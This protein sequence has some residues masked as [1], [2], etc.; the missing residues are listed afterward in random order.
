VQKNIRK[1]LLA[2]NDRHTCYFSAQSISQIPESSTK[3]A[4]RTDALWAGAWACAVAL[5][6]IDWTLGRL[7][8]LMSKSTLFSRANCVSF[9]RTRQNQHTI[10]TLCPRLADSRPHRLWSA[11][12]FL[13]IIA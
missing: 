6:P 8:L 7:D 2:S 13:F 11:A 4:I 3:A 9:V 1:A 12:Y 10:P 5:V